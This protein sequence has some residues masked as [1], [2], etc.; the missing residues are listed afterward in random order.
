[1]KIE[2]R[3]PTRAEWAAITSSRPVVRVLERGESS[4][5]EN[6][7]TFA[8]MLGGFPLFST[9]ESNKCS[10]PTSGANGHSKG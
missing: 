9:A 5:P 8:P 4:R 7:D 1:V 10:T 6:R 3:K 2:R